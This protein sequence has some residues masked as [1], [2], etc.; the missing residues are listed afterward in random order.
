MCSYK[1]TL[2]PLQ[3]LTNPAVGIGCGHVKYMAQNYASYGITESVIHDPASCAAAP[4][5]LKCCASA[6]TSSQ[7]TIHSD[8]FMSSRPSHQTTPKQCAFSAQLDPFQ[9]FRMMGCVFLFPPRHTYLLLQCSSLAWPLGSRPKSC[10]CTTL[11]TIYTLSFF[12][13][14][15]ALAAAQPPLPVIPSRFRRA[16]ALPSS[17]TRSKPFGSSNGANSGVPA[18]ACPAPCMCQRQCSLCGR[19]AKRSF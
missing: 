2:K 4:S 3:L 19:V 5:P 13:I 1:L 10:L 11:L 8:Q 18:S 12:R 9:P 17:Q 15:T 14:I 6:R 16:A 7:R